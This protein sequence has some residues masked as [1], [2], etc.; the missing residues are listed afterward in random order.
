MCTNFGHKRWNSYT[1]RESNFNPIARRLA[2]LKPNEVF[3]D[4][5]GSDSRLR[6]FGLTFS[7]F[8]FMVY[9]L[10]TKKIA[11]NYL[12]PFSSFRNQKFC[13]QID[14]RT[15]GRTFAKSFCF[16]YLVKNIYTCP[17]LSRLFLKFHPLMT[18]LV[19]LFPF[20]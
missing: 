6:A 19:Y 18:K 4:I 12:Y 11:L 17:Y 5:P 10:L 14:G 13:R 15:V 3:N 1:Y 16:C 20:L 9:T 2:K 8:R 7:L